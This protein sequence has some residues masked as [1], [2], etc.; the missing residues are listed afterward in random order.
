LRSAPGKEILLSP[1]VHL[2]TYDVLTL[3]A[4][5]NGVPMVS[6]RT[7]NE[8]ERATALCPE[9]YVLKAWE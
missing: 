4:H 8:K 6:E 5:E 9:V 1:Y 3:V 7:A 2:N